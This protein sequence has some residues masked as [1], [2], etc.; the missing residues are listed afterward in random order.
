MADKKS[1]RNKIKT[2]NNQ[3]IY[4]DFSQEDSNI[5]NKLI[6]NENF[7]KAKTILLYYPLNNEVNVIP[8]INYC[9]KI[10]KKVGL[11]KIY[12][13]IIKFVKID[14][15]WEYNLI[16][17]KYN[18]LEPNSN[19]IINEFS[20]ETLIIIPALAFD[21]NNSRIGHGKGYYDKFLKNKNIYKI[22]LTRKHL[23][24]KTVPTKENDIYLDK[25]ISIN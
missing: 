15:Q 22:G 17:G 5:I 24:F 4:K 23:L 20:K 3:N 16:K 2:I 8:L 21:E 12:D 7:I 10:N 11:P 1:F 6:Q 13:D 19:Q 25:I 14:F 9:L 18:I